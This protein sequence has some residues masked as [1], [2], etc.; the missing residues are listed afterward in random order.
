MFCEEEGREEVSFEG[1][2]SCRSL[3]EDEEESEKESGKYEESWN[4]NSPK[5]P[6]S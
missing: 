2:R 6:E 1:S 3:V 4:Q 5:E